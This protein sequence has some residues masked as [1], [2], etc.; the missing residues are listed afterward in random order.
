M[1]NLLGF[2]N[3]QNTKQF[4]LEFCSIH[5]FKTIAK[6]LWLSKIALPLFAGQGACCRC[7]SV[8]RTKILLKLIM[9]KIK[10]HYLTY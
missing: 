5:A 7:L 4:Y 10:P 9:S 2:I 1:H 3:L 6:F 8:N